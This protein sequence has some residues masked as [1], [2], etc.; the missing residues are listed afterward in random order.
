[1]ACARRSVLER[2]SRREWCV[3]WRRAGSRSVARRREERSDAARACRHF[4][5]HSFLSR[6]N[7]GYYRGQST[8]FRA[9]LSL[10][11]LTRAWVPR[12]RSTPII[13]MAGKVAISEVPTEAQDNGHCRDPAVGIHSRH[14][15]LAHS[16]GMRLCA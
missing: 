6:Y 16:V 3:L 11:T 4:S 9:H 8:R 7:S 2:G 1:M 13:H 14:T 12:E 10:P 5:I 15:C